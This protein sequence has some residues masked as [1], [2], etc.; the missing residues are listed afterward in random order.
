[1]RSGENSIS[2]VKDVL[3]KY[4]ENRKIKQITDKGANIMQIG[5]T[6]MGMVKAIRSIPKRA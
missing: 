2:I 6:N 5:K 1:M 4:G 3:N